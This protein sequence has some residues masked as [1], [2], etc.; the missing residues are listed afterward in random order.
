VAK[1]LPNNIW[2][3]DGACWHHMTGQFTPHPA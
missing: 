1:K 2:Q 3:Q